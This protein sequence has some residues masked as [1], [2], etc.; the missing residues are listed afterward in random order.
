[1]LLHTDG[2]TEHKDGTSRFKDTRLENILIETKVN[3]QKGYETI[4]DYIFSALRG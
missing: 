4:K 2:L 3:L 1:M